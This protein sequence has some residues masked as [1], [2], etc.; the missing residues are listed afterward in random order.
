MATDVT[1]SPTLGH[2]L[3]FTQGGV[4]A[5]PGYDAIDLRRYMQG[6]PAVRP[7]AYDATGWKVQPRAAG[8][9]MTVEVLASVGLARVD[10]VAASV[11]GPYIV[12]PHN[13]TIGLDVA[14]AHATL[15]RIDTVIL[16]VRDDTHDGSGAYDARVRIL[17]GTATSGATLDNRSGAPTLPSAGFIRLADVLVTAAATSISAAN[18]RDYRWHAGSEVIGAVAWFS[19]D[20][21]GLPP[22]WRFAAANH[23]KRLVHDRLFAFQGVSQG[24]GDGSTTFT[25]PDMQDRVPVGTLATYALGQT[26]G[27]AT[28]TLT[29][30]QLAAHDHRVVDPGH[31][32]Q[33]ALGHGAGPFVVPDLDES[34][35]SP[36]TKGLYGGDDV[37]PAF[38]G[39]SVDDVGEAR[40]QAHDNMPP[41]RALTPA[42]YT[43]SLG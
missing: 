6:S 2:A 30:N 42:V 35:G 11:L 19:G 23:V 1:V 22:G 28:V 33:L 27:A 3:L 9:N 25:L 32:H 15:P 13:S 17:A 41:F 14:T 34:S 10:G 8:A 7:G 37:Y 38:T 26:G 39:I 43:G 12:A 16:Q 21:V 24:A 40:N 29:A 31:V 36:N 18:I 4:G 20:P 5:T